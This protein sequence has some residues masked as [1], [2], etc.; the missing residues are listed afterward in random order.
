LWRNDL[1]LWGNVEDC[2][3]LWRRD[4]GLLIDSEEVELGLWSI[5][6]FSRPW[7]SGRPGLTGRE[8]GK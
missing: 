3:D 4:L 5:G 8:A 6:V 1:F 2:G 7:R